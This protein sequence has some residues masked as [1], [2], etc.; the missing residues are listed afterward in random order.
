[1]A[2]EAHS[3]ERAA[4]ETNFAADVANLLTTQTHTQVGTRARIRGGRGRGSPLPPAAPA[5]PLAHFTLLRP[6]TLA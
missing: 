2:G 1:V 3:D 5:P 4:F 6:R